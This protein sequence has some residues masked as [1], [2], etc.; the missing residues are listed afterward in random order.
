MQGKI[1]EPTP[2]GARKVCQIY[3]TKYCVQQPT[4]YHNKFHF[5]V[6]QMDVYVQTVVSIHHL[7]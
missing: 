3:C 5:A 2:P 4:L 7:L 6:V 1:F